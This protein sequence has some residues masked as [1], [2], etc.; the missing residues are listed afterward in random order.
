[1]STID[2]SERGSP[3]LAT[4]AVRAGQVRG[5]E[6]EHSEPIYTTSSFVFASAAEAAARFAGTEPGNV[7]SRFTNP[8]VRA[9]EERLNALEGGLRC[10]ATATGMAAISATTL[11]LCQAG[12]HV[13]SSRAVFGASLQWF[14]QWLPRYGIQVTLVPQDDLEA[15]R[16]ALAR[17]TRLVFLE[18]PSNPLMRLADIAALAELAHAAGALLAVDNCFCTPILQRPFE[19]GADLVIH[20]A[21]KYLDGQ[22]RLL[23]GAILARDAAVAEAIYGFLRTAGPSMSAMNAWVFLKG[24]ETLPLRMRAHS[25]AALIVARWLETRPEVLRVYYPFLDSHPQQALAH[26]QQSAGGGIVSFELHGGRE[27]AWRLIDALRWFSITANLGDTRSTVTHPATTTH[28]RLAAETRAAAGIGDN[29]VRLSIGIEA[30]EDLLED[31]DAA[32]R[33]CAATT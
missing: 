21:T 25:E 4:R 6:G 8:T 29:L 10:I 20:S 7:Y 27:A 3:R 23:G 33:C 31:L 18:T 16:E 9:F 2:N 17:P 30:V 19:L 12:D 5:P 14:E 15:W 24:L 13:V 26:L 32:L 11:A 1:M 22:G 28:G